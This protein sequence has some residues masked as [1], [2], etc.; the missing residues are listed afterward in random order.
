MSLFVFLV[1]LSYDATYDASLLSKP[2]LLYCTL[3]YHHGTQEG[4]MCRTTYQNITYKLCHFD[5]VSSLYKLR[6][7]TALFQTYTES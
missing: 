7:Y 2:T 5:T 3:L 1:L 6:V 4:A